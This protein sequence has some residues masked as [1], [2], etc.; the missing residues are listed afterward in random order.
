[1]LIYSAIYKPISIFMGFLTKLVMLIS[2]NVSCG[3]SLKVRGIVIL[4]ISRK[5]RL[6][7]GKNVRLNSSNYD[8]H[9]NMFSTVK[10]YIEG[11]AVVSIGDNSRVHGVCIH[12]RSSVKI[13]K[14]CLIAANTNIIDCNGHELSMEAPEN[15]INSIGDAFNVVIEDN[16]WIGAGVL[17][18][19]GVKIGFGSVIGA[20][21][22]VA[23]SMPPMSLIA[24][25]PARVVKIFQ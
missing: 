14:N 17:I 11:D 12:A 16:V 8:Y 5:G 9:L 4:N 3:K 25:N 24:G 6:V 23:K 1:M 2:G 22:V 18:L 15:R 7:I 19:P 13:G 21:S 10:F 20:G